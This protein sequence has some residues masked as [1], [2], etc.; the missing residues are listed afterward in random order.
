MKN[1]LGDGHIH[2]IK[3]SAHT[4]CEKNA[5]KITMVNFT[6]AILLPTP[7]IYSYWLEF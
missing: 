7:N 6:Q 4:L 2:S 5:Q 3:H 1:V